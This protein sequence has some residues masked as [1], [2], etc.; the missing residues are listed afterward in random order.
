MENMTFNLY[1]TMKFSTN[2]LNHGI[3]RYPMV[4]GMCKAD[5]FVDTRWYHVVSTNQSALHIGSFMVAS[6]TIRKWCHLISVPWFC[7]CLVHQTSDIYSR[8]ICIPCYATELSFEIER[9][10]ICLL[11][12][13]PFACHGVSHIPDTFSSLSSVSVIFC[14]RHVM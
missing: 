6:S 5:W 2:L 11:Y 3:S 8:S 4:K 1:G 7:F 9:P 10:A 14:R 12:H 13:P